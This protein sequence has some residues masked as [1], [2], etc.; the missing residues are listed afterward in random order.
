[1]LRQFCLFTCTCHFANIQLVVGFLALHTTEGGELQNKLDS[2]NGDAL[3]LE[4]SD[5]RVAR[6]HSREGMRVRQARLKAG[7]TQEGLAQLAGVTTQTIWRIENEATF[8]HHIQTLRLIAK[9]LSLNLSRLLNSGE[10]AG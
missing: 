10:T 7:L 8:N 2:E 9:A 3:A 4:M 1:M 6:K 5:M